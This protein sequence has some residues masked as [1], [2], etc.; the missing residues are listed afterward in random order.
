[1]EANQWWRR[2][3]LSMVMADCGWLR[4]VAHGEEENEV[5]RWKGY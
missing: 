3:R 2:S 5:V 1:V 4:W